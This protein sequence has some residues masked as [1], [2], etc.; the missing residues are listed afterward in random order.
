L[1][2][3]ILSATHRNLEKMV[4]EGSFREDLFYRLNVLSLEVPPLRERGHDI[5]LL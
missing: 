5:L 2:V 4:A 1:D 3:R